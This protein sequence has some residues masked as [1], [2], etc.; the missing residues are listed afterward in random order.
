MNKIDI[1][2]LTYEQLEENIL[3][4]GEKKFRSGQIFSWLHEKRVKTFDEMTN[5]STAFREKL[6]ETFYLPVLEI[7]Q[8]LTSKLDGT[9]K[10]LFR[11]EDGNVIES[12]YMV[13][14]HG[15]SVCVSSQVGCRMGCRFCASTIDGLAR[16]LRA[17]EILEQIYRIQED[18]KTR[19]SHVVIMGAGE[20]M[21]NYEE[22]VRFIRLVSDSRGIAIGQRN[23]TVS[24]C[25]IVPRMRAFAE[26]GLQ[27]TLALSLHA[28]NNEVRKRLMPIANKYPLDEV[29]D[30]CRYY[31][32]QTG[33]RIT[34]EYSLVFG[35]ND[36]EKEANELGK[37][38]KGF[39]CH[40]N[41]IPVNPV[42]ETGFIRPDRKNIV[43]F[44]NILEKYGINV[45]IRREM[46]QDINGACGQLRK[47]YLNNKT[48]R[49]SR[50]AGIL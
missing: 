9:K 39:G 18:V 29:L 19:V 28:P 22:V 1:K 32:D 49:V 33:R 30:A 46:G 5:L 15:S 38:L 36:N 24:T 44:K 4:L 42:K 7:E 3:A 20:P 10:Y 6:K 25:G 41:L 14:Q 47:S 16:D 50:D 12:V 37:R 26:E 27:V 11:L 34:M 23:I 45:T 40:L 48:E 8:V 2:S 21:D 43:L 17:S 13:Y 31:F 35:V